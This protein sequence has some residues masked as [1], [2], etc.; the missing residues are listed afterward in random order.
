MWEK[1]AHDA[2]PW[3]ESGGHRA[4]PLQAEERGCIAFRFAW[5]AGARSNETDTLPDRAMTMGDLYDRALRLG[6]Q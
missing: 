3:L 2:A 6:L 5:P 4:R 1:N